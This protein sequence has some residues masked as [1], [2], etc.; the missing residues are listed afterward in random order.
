MASIGAAGQADVDTGLRDRALDAMGF[1]E[2]VELLLHNDPASGWQISE[3]AGDSA[4]RELPNAEKLLRDFL[5]PAGYCREL[6][7]D[8]FEPTTTL[9]QLAHNVN[10]TMI[11]GG[12]EGVTVARREF[13]EYTFVNRFKAQ[14]DPFGEVQKLAFK[15]TYHFVPVLAGFPGVGP[16][17]GKVVCFIDP[18]EG[19]WVIETAELHD[20]GINEFAKW[21]QEL[22]ETGGATT[23][24]APSPTSGPSPVPLPPLPNVSGAW[25]GTIH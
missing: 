6:G 16:F 1:S 15:F 4:L 14:H 18:M 11:T 20:E 25:G 19:T 2:P 13:G 7:R 10:A 8:R 21:I 9:R 24:Q 23:E 12:L 17:E 5:I 3:L 22:P